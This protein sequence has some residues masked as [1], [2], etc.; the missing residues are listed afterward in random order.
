M[1]Q[2]SILGPLLFLIY[3]NDLAH[4]S[5][6]I[7]S[8]LFADDSNLFLTGKNPNEL[9]QMMNTEISYVFDWL[10]VNKLSINLKKNSLYDFPEEK[11]KGLCD[12]GT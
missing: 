8:I 3:I 7:F 5:S 12:A 4:A 10:Q 6:R 2:G 9:I 11:T 1:P